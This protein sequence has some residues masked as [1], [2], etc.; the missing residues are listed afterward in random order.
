MRA[1]ICEPVLS[2]MAH[3]ELSRPA[4]SRCL[5]NRRSYSLA[6]NGTSVELKSGTAL[7]FSGVW[8]ASSA[9]RKKSSVESIKLGMWSR[10][11]RP[12]GDAAD[13][14]RTLMPR[15]LTGC[16]CPDPV[17]IIIVVVECTRS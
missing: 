9:P 11:Q 12:S 1:I 3:C 7:L 15:S 10:Y 5:T 4:R 6:F 14:N 16:G 17:Y 13:H 8:P 2:T